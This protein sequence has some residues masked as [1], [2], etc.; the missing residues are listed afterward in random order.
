VFA[1]SV[2]CP[3]TIWPATAVPVTASGAD[4]QPIELGVK[5]RADMDGLITSIRF[6]KSPANTGTHTAHLWKSDGTS[7]AT[8]TFVNETASGWQQVDFPSPVAITAGTTY[9]AS[10]HTDK[11][12]YAGDN[13]YFSTTGVDN[14]PLHAL[15]D[16]LAGGNGVYIYG[17]SAFPTNSFKGSNYWIDVVFTPNP[18]NCPCALWHPA[19]KPTQPASPDTASV[20]LGVKFRSETPGF[21][22][23]VRFYKFSTNT[24]THVA[25]LWAANGALLAT[26]TFTTETASGWQQANFA[27]P[28]AI[29]G[30]TIY[31][32]SYH[33]NTGHYAS[34]ERYFLNLGVDK[35]PLHAPVNSQASSNGIYLYGTVA[36]FPTS[37]FN[38]SNYWVDVAF[39]PLVH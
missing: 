17:A 30:D 26:T 8:A 21:L 5:F 31:V 3:C 38:A 20:E 23:G 24:G 18:T 35:P 32:A 28:I 25:H 34:D 19:V 9:V 22:T 37:T 12:H 7:L 29:N 36:G 2:T 33:T 14:W 13:A 4:T 39:Q 11:G 15:K 27:T 16:G 6:Y 1:T 10:Y